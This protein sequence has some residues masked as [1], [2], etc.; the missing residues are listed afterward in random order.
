LRRALNHGIDDRV[1]SL[2]SR[3]A[4]LELAL[5]TWDTDFSELKVSEGRL[6]AAEAATTAVSFSHANAVEFLDQQLSTIKKA[7]PGA[8]SLGAAAV[9]KAHEDADGGKVELA[10]VSETFRQKLIKGSLLE[11]QIILLQDDVSSA[12][13]ACADFEKELEKAR[14]S[15]LL[16]NTS[17]AELVS[18][19]ETQILDLNAQLE[20]PIQR[21]LKS[22]SWRHESFI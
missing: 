11:I 21:A 22:E 17:S 8:E 10:S 3:V 4:D 2:L 13:A 14:E 20:N 1:Q 6:K 5:T 18:K 9:S 19:L 7:L 16:Q 15:K 12:K